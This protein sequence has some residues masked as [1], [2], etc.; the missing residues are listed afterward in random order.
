[1]NAIVEFVMKNG[2][3]VLFAV[4]FAQQ[5]G[6]P[7]PG[8]VFLVAVGALLAV[9]KLRL[10]PTL[11]LAV[12]GCVLAD[13]VWYE[14]GRRRGD[15]VL[16]FIHRLTRDPDAHDRRTKETFA[17]YGHRLLVVAKFVPGL[18]GIAPPLA[19]T[20]GT[21]RLRFL[22]LDTV[23]AGLYSCVYGGLGYVFS[24]DLDHATAY[25]GRVG[26]ILAGVAFAALSIYEVRKIVLR[27]RSRR[28]PEFARITATG[29]MR[30]AG[31]VVDSRTGGVNSTLSPVS[32]VTAHSSAEKSY[33]YG[34]APLAQLLPLSQVR[35]GTQC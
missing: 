18:D 20:S 7:L 6:V 2:Y 3:S 25:A 5:A 12:V 23:G 29:S 8:P 32:P 16:H 33:G 9:G 24:H 15:K 27:H 10:I 28:E 11:V 4:M 22:A 30:C 19:G 34:R 31:T 35:G 14:A 21:S 1:M 26:A 13:W 17:R